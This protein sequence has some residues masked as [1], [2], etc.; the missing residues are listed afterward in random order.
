MLF[1]DERSRY[2]YENKRKQANLSDR[3]GD[4]SAQMTAMGMTFY[5]E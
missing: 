4:I 2:V 5:A 3:K 1:Y